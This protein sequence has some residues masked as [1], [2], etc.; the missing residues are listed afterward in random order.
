M[1]HKIEKVR[2]S[3]NLKFVLSNRDKVNGVPNYTSF[4]IVVH[5]CIPTLTVA[6]QGTLMHS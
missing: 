2:V 6:K 1:G 4:S 3:K 5:H